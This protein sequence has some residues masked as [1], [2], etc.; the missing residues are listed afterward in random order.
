M[1][2]L[3]VLAHECGDDV[4]RVVWRD[5]DEFWKH[6]GAMPD[7]ADVFVAL[8]VWL[9]ADRAAVVFAAMFP[10]H[11]AT[12][13]RAK[14]AKFSPLDLYR[15]AQVYE[16]SFSAVPPTRCA[17]R[18]STP[19]SRRPRGRRRARSPARSTGDDPPDDPLSP[20][21]SGRRGVLRGAS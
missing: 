12:V 15:I 18:R 5:L 14:Q 6:N 17:A 19:R 20:R 16:R 4:A 7:E 21:E 10:E 13:E 8:V 9:D 3:D 2:A 1:T 11:A